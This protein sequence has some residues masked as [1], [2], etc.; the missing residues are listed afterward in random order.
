[1]GYDPS[2]AVHINASVN[3]DVFVSRNPR[4]KRN[5]IR[6]HGVRIGA[7]ALKTHWVHLKISEIDVCGFPHE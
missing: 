3:V 6:R 2:F 1:M 4:Q 5:G 7:T